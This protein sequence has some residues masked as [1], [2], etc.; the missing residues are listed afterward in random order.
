MSSTNRGAT[1]KAA[2]AYFTPE[3]AFRPLLPHLYRD[4][5]YWEPACGDGRLIRWMRDGGLRA[6]GRDLLV[7]Y[8]FLKDTTRRQTIITNPPFSLAQEFC[9]HAIRH[10]PDVIMLLRLNFLGSQ[11]RAKWWTKHE[12]TALFVLAER[13]DFTG[14]GG[15]SCEY[16]WFCWGARYSG[17]HHLL[18][19]REVVEID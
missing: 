13:P 14:D 3:S 19:G 9:D 5:E 16:A 11:K 17:I 4:A 10:A 12:P 8:D 1:R 15:D 7:G 2:D 18:P 6:D